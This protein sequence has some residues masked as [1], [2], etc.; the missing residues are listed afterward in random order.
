[1]PH[2]EHL[3]T[4]QS[5]ISSRLLQHL[6]RLLSDITKYMQQSPGEIIKLLGSYA[7]IC[8]CCP[9]PVPLGLI[10]KITKPKIKRL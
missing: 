9:L 1:M 7:Y 4:H 5:L 3:A 6:L 10:K 8:N 2:S